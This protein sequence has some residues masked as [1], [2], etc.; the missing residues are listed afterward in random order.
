[1]RKTWILY[2]RG[3]DNFVD[4]FQAWLP[5]V[6]AQSDCSMKVFRANGGR[7]FISAKFKSFCE[8]RGIIIRYGVPYVHEENG[9]AERGWRIIATMQDSMLIDSG[10]PNGFWAETM[11]TA[12]YLQ[13]KLPMRSKNHGEVIPKEAWTG[14]RQD[15]QYVQI[16]G[17]LTLS[18]IPAVKRT[19]FDYQKV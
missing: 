9:L 12:N 2:L 13:N 18:N 1:M 8:K 11:E 5:R 10:L 6:E 7:K 15:L 16:F 17:N 4:A 3:K 19:K 14:Q